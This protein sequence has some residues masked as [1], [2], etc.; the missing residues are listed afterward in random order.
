MADIDGGS[1][2]RVTDRD[3][4]RY[5]EQW[6][7]DS[8]EKLRR[9]SWPLVMEEVEEKLWQRTSTWPHFLAVEIERDNMFGCF[10]FLF[11]EEK[12]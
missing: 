2:G 7:T 3:H 11:I 4:R 5:L 9:R 6:R 1:E 8:E 12:G 10:F